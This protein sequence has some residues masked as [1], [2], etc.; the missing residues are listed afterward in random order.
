VLD[1]GGVRGGKVR[2]RSAPGENST[3]RIDL[4]YLMLSVKGLKPVQ[5]CIEVLRDRSDG[6]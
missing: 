4:L 5:L 6:W 3:C 2:C 1:R